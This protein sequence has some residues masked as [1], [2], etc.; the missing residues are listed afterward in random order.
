LTRLR[1]EQVAGAV[2]QAASLPSLGPQSPWYVRFAAWT[3]RNDFVKRYGDMGED[4]FASCSGTIPQRL[5]MMNGEL[6]R[7]KA[8]DGLFNASQ[9]IAEQAPTDRHA[10]EVAYLTVLTRRPTPEERTHFESRLAGTTGQER[11]DRLTD[12]FWTLLNA[13]EFS[14]NH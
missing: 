11:K 13:T 5:L 1:P 2:L 14:W 3:G 4:E 10:V 12:L 6:V 9:R 8:G 7:E